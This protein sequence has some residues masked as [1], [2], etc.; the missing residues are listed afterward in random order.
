M[1]S[2]STNTFVQ[3][4]HHG[5][6]TTFR[7]SGAAQMSLILCAAYDDGV[8]FT[9]PGDRAK[10][11]NLRRDPRCTLVVSQDDWWGYLV[12]EGRAKI[13]EADNTDADKLSDTLREVYDR[14]S[15]E[16]P[17]WDEYDRVMVEERRAVV[18]VVPEHV[19]GPQA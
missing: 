12:L 11:R 10:L 17:D 13:M 18:V 2:E 15:G 19:Y 8:A 1:F 5:V 9:T 16:H 14:I 3:E 7:R 6:L 4:N